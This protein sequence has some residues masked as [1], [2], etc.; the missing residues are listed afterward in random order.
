MVLKA[1][2]FAGPTRNGARTCSATLRTKIASKSTHDPGRSSNSMG[3]VGES[4]EVRMMDGTGE[5]VHSSPPSPNA[6]WPSRRR[7]RAQTSAPTSAVLATPVMAIAACGLARLHNDVCNW[8]GEI[9]ASFKFPQVVARPPA[10]MTCPTFVGMDSTGV[11]LFKVAPAAWKLHVLDWGCQWKLPLH[12][13][14]P[15]PLQWLS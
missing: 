10:R 7:R 8:I 2:D 9:F 11:W 15:L 13:E 12:C 5:L 1:K 6:T 14:L 3:M 4:K